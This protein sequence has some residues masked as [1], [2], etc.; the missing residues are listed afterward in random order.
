MRQ[1]YALLPE[2]FETDDLIALCGVKK[3]NAEKM[4]ERLISEQYIKRI[5]RGFYQKLFLYMT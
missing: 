3:R 5:E 1:R 2:V 4:I